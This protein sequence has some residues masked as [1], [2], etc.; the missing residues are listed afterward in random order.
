MKY[1]YVLQNGKQGTSAEKSVEVDA[2]QWDGEKLSASVD[3]L[4]EPDGLLDVMKVDT[5]IAENG[6]MALSGTAGV[7]FVQPNSWVVRMPNG[8]ITV[9]S[10]AVFD[11]CYR[12]AASDAK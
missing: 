8:D 7:V 5:M 1:R 6:Q 9:C 3:W 12:P 10:S 11:R 2:V 4:P